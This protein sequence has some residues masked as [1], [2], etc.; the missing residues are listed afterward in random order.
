MVL[1]LDFRLDP[2]WPLLLGY[3]TS[4]LSRA[5][6]GC[7]ECSAKSVQNLNISQ[8]CVTSGILLWLTVSVVLCQAFLSCAL[9]G[10]YLTEDSVRLLGRFWGISALH[11]SSHLPCPQNSSPL[12]VLNSNCY[13]LC[14]VRLQLFPWTL[15]PYAMPE[16]APG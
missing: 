6:A 5:S 9:S 7:L 1:D 11:R 16:N 12:A 14:S 10:L 4:G 2:E 3:S 15:R 8:Y 13:F